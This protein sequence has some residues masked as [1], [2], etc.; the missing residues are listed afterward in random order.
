MIGIDRLSDSTVPTAPVP[1]PMPRRQD[2]QMTE[3][4]THRAQK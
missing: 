4:E 3:E 1:T 2:G